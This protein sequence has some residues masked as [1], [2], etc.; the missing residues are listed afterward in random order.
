MAAGDAQRVWFANMV[1]QL[2]S[3]WHQ[4]MSFETIVALGGVPKAEWA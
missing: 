2:R 4:G 1:E 3:Q